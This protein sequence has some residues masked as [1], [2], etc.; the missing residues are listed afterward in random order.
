MNMKK[1]TLAT[2]V[3]LCLGT[4]GTANAL[5][6]GITNM[7]FGGIY[8]ANGFMYDTDTGQF[9]YGL[10]ISTEDFNGHA[11]TANAVKFFNT[12]SQP[13]T[14]TGTFEGSPW[15]QGTIT[16]FTQTTQHTP[17]TGVQT[18]TIPLTTSGFHLT[19]NQV[20]WGTLFNW[21]TSVNIPVLMVFDCA[22]GEAGDLCSGVSGTP[23][24]AGPFAGADPVFN[25]SILEGSTPFSGGE[26][27]IPAA[28][29][30]F[31]SGLVGLAGIARRRKQKG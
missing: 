1:T 16:G 29:W 4:T 22:P 19:G 14:W 30:L 21:S 26:V 8:G 2:T 17:F 9:G 7:D 11:W 31:G 20:A 28:A 24:A 18:N 13:L 5:K 27:P 25:G 15:A 10:A 23:M 12:H 6:I 3:A